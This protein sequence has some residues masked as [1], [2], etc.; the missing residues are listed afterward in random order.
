MRIYN[1]EFEDYY[2]KLIERCRKRYP[3]G[4]RKSWFKALNP[5]RYKELG[6]FFEVLY[7]K[8]EIYKDD[9]GLYKFSSII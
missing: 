2:K 4:F 7:S 9:N 6:S 5:K 3:K 8:G 1:K